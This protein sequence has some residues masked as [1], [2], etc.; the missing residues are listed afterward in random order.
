MGSID[1]V[2]VMSDEIIDILSKIDRLD[3][4]ID[5]TLGLGGHALR[6][7]STFPSVVILG[8]DQDEEALAVASKKLADF[9]DRVML[10]KSNFKLIDDIVMSHLSGRLADAVLFD[11]GVSSMQVD[12]EERGFSFNKEGPLDMRMD[13]QGAI[14][15]YDLINKLT[16]DELTEIFYKYGE[17]RYSH[18]LAKA[19][20]RYRERHGQ[21]SSTTELVEIVRNALPARIQR[22]MGK[23]PARK[24]F[25]ALRIVVNDEINALKQGLTKSVD[26]VRSGGVIIVLSYHSLEDRLV[27]HTFKQWESDGRGRLYSKKP[28]LPKPEEVERN[29]RSRSAKLRAFIKS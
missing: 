22:H 23:H 12:D 2:P 26:C 5:A 9:K 21:I 8:V 10:V 1:H 15:A 17:E 11:L 24:I 6:I 3:L 28:I 19:I 25:Q 4:L 20:V 13:K 14:S 7:C 18:L 27:K 29:P 16:V